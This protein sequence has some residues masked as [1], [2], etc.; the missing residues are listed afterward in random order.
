MGD[1]VEEWHAGL[2]ETQAHM[3]G[4]LTQRD[5]GRWHVDQLR[6][7]S[8]RDF[9]APQI[10]GLPQYQSITDYFQAEREL[11]PGELAAR[12][13]LGELSDP[14]M[15]LTDDIFGSLEEGIRTGF[16]T[17]VSPLVTQMENYYRGTALPDLA[18]DYI[19]TSGLS[20][21]DF[22]EAVARLGR[23]LSSDIGSLQFQADETAAARRAQ[24]T[25]AAPGIAL[26]A[27]TG[28]VNMAAY[29]QQMREQEQAMEPGAQLWPLYASLQGMAQYD[30][31]QTIVSPGGTSGAAT[32][33]TA[34]G[35][36]LNAMSSG[37]GT[38]S[39]ATSSGSVEQP[40]DDLTRRT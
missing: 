38:G 8:G 27:F 5:D 7:E 22:G 23:D 21:S 34:V 14:Y 18:E 17:D 20:G 11:S 29:F 35:G 10:F 28:P 16:R 2:G 39:Y 13:K 1:K 37:S 9:S 25:E 3:L 36:L 24:F 31:S 6:D 4:H 26:R 32:W 19:G 30:P 15:G 33:M 12:S 40:Q